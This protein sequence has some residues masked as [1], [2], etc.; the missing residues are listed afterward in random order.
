MPMNGAGAI[1]IV[2]VRRPKEWREFHALPARLYRDRPAWVQPLDLYVR[3]TWA[4]RNP[5]FAHLDAAAWLA[6]RDGRTLGRISAQDDRLQA[7]QGRADLGLF[8]Q[9][10]AVD[11]PAVFA[12]L[13]EAASDWLRRRGKRRL[14]GPFDLTINQQCG[15]LVDGFECSPAMMMNYHLPYYSARLE[16]LGFTGAADM[17]AYRGATDSPVPDT[18]TRLLERTASRISFRPVRRRDVAAQAELMR[19]LFNASWAGNWGFIPFTRE[20]FALMVREMKPLLREN[21][22]QIA[23][24]DDRPVGFI[25]ALPD[26]NGLIRDLGGRL[27]PTGWIRL[28]WRLQRCRA[29]MVRIPL[30]GV[31]PEHHRRLLGA[32]IAWGLIEAVRAPILADGIRHSEQSWILAQNHGMRAIVEALGMQ[33]AARYRIYEKA[34]VE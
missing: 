23:W 28:L 1:E 26:L 13:L 24:L 31:R 20:E 16:Q 17:L 34:L 7:D 14:Q 25:V 18:V 9:L 11:E 21:Y 33:V 12:A 19:E 22:V 10:E 8:G 32:A 4:P 3:Q 5:V 2:P 6:R 15:L 30:M 29:G 27:F